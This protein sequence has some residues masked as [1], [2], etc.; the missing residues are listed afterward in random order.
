MKISQTTEC[1][2]FLMLKKTRFG[3]ANGSGRTQGLASLSGAGGLSRV[4][5]TQTLINCNPILH[6]DFCP[7]YVE[8][9]QQYQTNLI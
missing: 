3:A 8:K 5:Q 7:K 1:L 4:T 2:D 9:K 6:K